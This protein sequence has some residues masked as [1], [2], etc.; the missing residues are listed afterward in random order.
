MP[1]AG[2]AKITGCGEGIELIADR[3]FGSCI[4][5][6]MARSHS[7]C[8]IRWPARGKSRGKPQD[9]ATTRASTQLTAIVGSW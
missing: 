8:L 2:H 4:S 5:A 6:N 9:S 1:I 3:R 7:E